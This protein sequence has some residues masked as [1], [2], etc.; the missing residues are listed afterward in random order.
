MGSLFGRLLRVRFN[1]M[2]DKG[3]DLMQAEDDN[4]KQR[5]KL[6]INAIRQIY[7]NASVDLNDFAALDRALVSVMDIAKPTLSQR[8]ALFDMLP[9]SVLGFGIQWG[10]DDTDVCDVIADFAQSNKE[11]LLTKI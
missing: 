11:A 7:W 3:K 8:K 1:L 10:F 2:E 9:Q 6:R 5:I 4:V